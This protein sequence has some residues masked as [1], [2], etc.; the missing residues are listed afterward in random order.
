MSPN[1]S[2]VNTERIARQAR[3]EK[4]KKLFQIFS[5]Q[6]AKDIQVASVE[7]WEEHLIM[8]IVLES[9]CQELKETIEFF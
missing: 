1:E 9:E 7:R 8:L 3:N 5:R 4:R 2:S 6:G